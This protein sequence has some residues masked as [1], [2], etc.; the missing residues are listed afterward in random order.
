M[1]KDAK[2]IT[3]FGTKGEYGFLSN[4]Y[5]PALFTDENIKF[6]CSEQFYQFKKANHFKNFKLAQKILLCKFPREQ[7]W[8]GRQIHNFD[9]EN[10]DEISYKVMLNAVRNKFT[11]NRELGELLLRTKDYILA[12]SSKD[13]IWGTGIAKNDPDEKIVDNWTGKSLL[14]DALMQI[15]WELDN[16]KKLR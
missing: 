9:Q 5:Q 15:R 7:K 13:K 3:F 12:E 14:G 11:K 8:R 16:P 1:N 4:F 10:W 2:I 6:N